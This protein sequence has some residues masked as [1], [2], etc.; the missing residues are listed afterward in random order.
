MRIKDKLWAFF[1]ERI[2]LPRFAGWMYLEKSLASRPGAILAAPSSPRR[3]AITPDGDF[4]YGARKRTMGRRPVSISVALSL[5]RNMNYSFTSLERNPPQLKTQ[6]DEFLGE[7]ENRARLLGVGALGYAKLPRELIFRDMAVLYDNVIVLLM[8]MDKVKISKAPSRETLSMIYST[9]DD[10][11]VA[12]NRLADFLREKGYAAQAGHP[13]GGL[14][15]YPPLAEL[16][17]L[18]WAR[19]TRPNH[20]ARIRT[21][22]E[23]CSRLY[24]YRESPD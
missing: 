4:K 24:E 23:D 3:F 15:L 11:S 14:A 12:A 5:M 9:Y 13:L 8:E 19:K 22:G 20:N 1:L 6:A 2:L 21:Q 18:G 17:C 16:A 7:F 10:L